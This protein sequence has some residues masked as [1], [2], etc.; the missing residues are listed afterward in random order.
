MKTRKVPL[1]AALVAAFTVALAA[2]RGD[3]CGIITHGEI[4]TRAAEDFAC[5]EHPEFEELVAD[6]PQALQAGAA[7]PDWGYAFGYGDE[8]EEAHWDPFLMEAADYVHELYPVWSADREKLAAFL[9][10]AASHHWA[11]LT[12]HALAGADEGFLEEMADQEYH[13][14]F[15]AAHDFGDFGGDVMCAYEYDQ[16]WQA[17]PWYVP[18]DDLA[19]IYARLG[20]DVSSFAISFYMLLLYGG[21]ELEGAADLLFARNAADSPFLV[22]QLQYYFLDGID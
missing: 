12:W 6:H 7:F 18:A 4:A 14:D 11:D 21:G 13:G 19:E 15:G 2:G 10:G 17:G 5:P 8:S 22:A 1:A 3:A 16:D 20:Y 9:L